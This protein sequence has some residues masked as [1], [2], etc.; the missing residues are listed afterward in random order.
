MLG[1]VPQISDQSNLFSYFAWI[2][3]FLQLTEKPRWPTL[4][5]ASGWKEILRT[6]LL[7][8]W[9]RNARV[10][11]NECRTPLAA[12]RFRRSSHLVQSL[13]AYPQPLEC[14]WAF[15]AMGVHDGQ[16]YRHRP[17]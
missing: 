7:R 17:A 6:C 2:G 11:P 10:C 16:R 15:T 4:I 12:V 5:D 9:T 3:F 8:R 1:R 14:R 13:R